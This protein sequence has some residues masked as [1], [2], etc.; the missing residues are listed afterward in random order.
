MNI[1]IFE[2][3]ECVVLEQAVGYFTSRFYS[4]A[5]SRTYTSRQT[6]TR[7]G[8]NAFPSNVQVAI[9][10]AGGYFKTTIDS[11]DLPR[12]ATLTQIYTS[13]AHM[14]HAKLA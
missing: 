12:I 2:Y 5:F 7:Y 4:K 8:M 11:K 6:C 3:S 1:S 14:R 9:F 10:R 13:C